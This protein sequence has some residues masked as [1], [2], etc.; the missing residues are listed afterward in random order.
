MNL[1]Y[2]FLRW[3]TNPILKIA[4]GI[5]GL[6]AVAAFYYHIIDLN[7]AA[8]YIMAYLSYLGINMGHS[9]WTVRKLERGGKP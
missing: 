5:G 9:E 3:F 2:R 4:L 7:T 6:V 1:A 8:T